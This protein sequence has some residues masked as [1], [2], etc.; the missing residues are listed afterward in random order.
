MRIFCWFCGKSVSNEVP[1]TTV[2]RAIA[3]CPECIEATQITLP[4]LPAP[5]APAAPEPEV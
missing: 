1:D 3:V 4:S 5:P 2:L